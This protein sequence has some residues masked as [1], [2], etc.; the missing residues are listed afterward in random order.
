MPTWSCQNAPDA[1]EPGAIRGEIVFEHVAFA[2]DPKEPVLKDVSFR[3]APG[4]AQEWFGVRADLATYGKIV[5]GGLPIGVVAGAARLGLHGWGRM[6]AVTRGAIFTCLAAL[7]WLA[8]AAS[9]R[10]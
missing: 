10:E 8:A 4:G 9:V 1:R 5:G 3:I 6:D 7:T 2:Y